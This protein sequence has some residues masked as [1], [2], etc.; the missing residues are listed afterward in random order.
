MKLITW[1]VNGVRAREAELLRLLEEE[2]PDVV[3]LQETK[4]TVEQLPA[5]LY[6]LLGLPDY[7]SIWHGSAGYSGVSLHL[8]KDVFERPRDA[9]PPFD[10]E[11]RVVEAHV[12]RKDGEAFV[13]VSMY[14]P[15]G[16]K[17]YQAKLEFMR[18]LASYPT[19][20]AAEN[21]VVAGDL[22]VAR[23]EM[24]VHESE[25]KPRAIGQRPE[26]RKLFEQ[27]LAAGLV[28]VC[29]ALAPDD[30]ELFT[31]WPYWNE[32]RARNVGWRIDYVLASKAIAA[33]AEAFRVR[34]DF[35]T[36]DHAP[37]VVEIADA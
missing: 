13:F 34:R 21:V 16:G 19:T 1:N 5:S 10:F 11:T 3:M 6:G 37:V 2:R 24:D 7:H 22:N 30:R 29:R 25:R 28:D 35:G 20:F 31:W 14:L 12:R 15:N 18:A 17:D 32:Q 33:R 8:R 23:A 26:E 27:F 36:S 4:A 9:H